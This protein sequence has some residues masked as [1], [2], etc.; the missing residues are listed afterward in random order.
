VDGAVKAAFCIFIIL[1]IQGLAIGE[2]AE[3]RT[4]IFIYSSWE[5]P[6]R[7]WV[8]VSCDGTLVAK[9][10]RGRFFSINVGPGTH[11]LTQ[12]DGIPLVVNARPGQQIFV[13]LEQQVSD[14]PSGKVVLPVLQ[15]VAPEQ[16]RKE[17]IHLVYVDSDKLYS[18]AVSREDPTQLIP[19]RLKQRGV[20]S[21]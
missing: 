15:V 9:V 21:D 16:A 17:I 4:G 3:Q 11:T 13:Q 18:S 10:K 8:P 12:N 19:P 5:Y 6:A 1:A 7:S 2:G 14:E 20:P